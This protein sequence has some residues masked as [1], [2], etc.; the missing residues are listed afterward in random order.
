MA[1]YLI[2]SEPPSELGG[3]IRTYIQNISA[4]CRSDGIQTTIVTHSPHAYPNEKTVRIKR[5]RLP[6]PGIRKLAYRFAYDT[7]V[8]LEQAYWLR[9]FFLGLSELPDRIEV[10]DFNGYGFFLVHT[11]RM[12]SRLILR[13]HTPAYMSIEGQRGPQSTIHRY[14]LKWM[15]QWAIKQATMITAPSKAFIDEKLPW[16]GPFFYLPNPAPAVVPIRGGHDAPTSRTGF[17]YIGRLEYRKGVLTLLA[18]FVNLLDRHPGCLLTLAGA[19]S[20]GA[21]AGRIHQYL[22]GIPE[23]KRNQIHFA[24]CLSK[25]ELHQSILNH[26]ACVIPSHWENSPY[27]FFEVVALG[28]CAI[29]T[30]TGEMGMTLEKLDGFHA[31]PGDINGLSTAMA[32][33]LQN[34]KKRSKLESLGPKYLAQCNKATIAD[35]LRVMG[36]SHAHPTSI[37]LISREYP[38]ANHV[39]GIATYTQA[40][41]TLLAENGHRVTVITHGLEK[42][43]SDEDGVLVHRIP[44]RPHPLPKHRF[45]YFYRHLVRKHLPVYLDALTWSTTVAA[46]IGQ[47]SHPFSFQTIEYPETMGE[48]AKFQTPA[49]IKRVCRIHFSPLEAITHSPLEGWLL[50]K[51]ERK[52]CRRAHRLVAPSHYAAGPYA[53]Q[54]LRINRQVRVSSNPIRLWRSPN[55]KSPDYHRHWLFAGRI[56][57]RKGI[58]IL[59]DALSQFPEVHSSITIRFTGALHA[60]TNP[61]DKKAQ[62]AFSALFQNPS[63]PASP[64]KPWRA[65]LTNHLKLEYLGMLPR[66]E[67][68]NQFDWADLFIIPSL[69]ENFPY[70]ALEAQSR[71]CYIIGTRVG[72]IPEIVRDIRFGMLFGRGDAHSLS[73]KLLF[74]HENAVSISNQN[75]ERAAMLRNRFSDEKCYHRLLE[76]YIF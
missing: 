26:M 16:I 32:D 66:K 10:P 36:C 42:S 27:A 46:Y 5:R 51:L 55:C 73:Q 33:C 59:A 50:R 14:T 52:G 60:A 70:V 13:I 65:T 9:H 3:G 43:V 45:F 15:E 74:Y 69:E 21:Y 34:P 35:T 20:E 19:E 71:G 57:Y 62:A 58:L 47:T 2:D 61:L 11:A 28:K 53:R 22:A 40:A 44:M 17:L 25:R 24:G 48:G 37:G 63:H 7:V 12:R 31:Q 41:A 38:P 76:T 54:N 30:R 8:L 64:H 18:A 6:L 68:K 75:Q 39:G 29:G 49:A 1:L 4:I 23:S 56:E 72:G 67:M